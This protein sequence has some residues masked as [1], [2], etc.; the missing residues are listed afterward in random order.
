MN[1]KLIIVV[2]LVALALIVY[3]VS[4]RSNATTSARTYNLSEF[5][6]AIDVPGTL[7]DLTHEVKQINPTP[8]TILEMR[9]D[10]TCTI[11][12]FYTVQK[13][14]LDASG[15]QWTEELLESAQFPSGGNPG[16]VKEFTDFYFVFEPSQAACSTN[17]ADAEREAA[18]RLALWNSLV[19]ARYMSY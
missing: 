9:V 10:E 7:S 4:Q 18:K 6:I 1:R 11:G 12:A 3:A 5:G 13:N 15:N 16:R 8:G 17:E 14:A 19:T 2:V